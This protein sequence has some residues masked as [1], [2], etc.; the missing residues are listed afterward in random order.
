VLSFV[1]RVEPWLIYDGLPMEESGR[2]HFVVEIQMNGD[3]HQVASV[4]LAVKFSQTDTDE[5]GI[6][7]S[8]EEA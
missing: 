1:V 7:P 4:P 3:W 6:L 2:H 8:L 5:E